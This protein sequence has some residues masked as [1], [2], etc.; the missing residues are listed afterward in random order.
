MSRLDAGLAWQLYRA[1]R[2]A[3]DDIIAKATA[4]AGR[5]GRWV[6]RGP[7][8]A[9]FVFSIASCGSMLGEV[10]YGI[11]EPCRTSQPETRTRRNSADRNL[12]VP[13]RM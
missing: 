11:C 2:Q 12:V 8:V 1:A 13:S 9:T 3:H 6:H 4:T 10:V 7:Q 5:C